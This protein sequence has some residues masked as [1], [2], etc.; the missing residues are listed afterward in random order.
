[1]A[2]FL[3]NFTRKGAARGRTLRDQTADLLEARLWGIG[4]KTANRDALAPEDDILLYVGAP[5]SAFIGHARLAEGTHTW[6]ED[7]SR[8]YPGAWDSGVSFEQASLWDHPIP[9]HSVIAE[10]VLRETNPRA[11]FFGGVVRMTK[12]DYET[13]L[14]AAKVLGSSATAPAEE[15][16]PVEPPGR[17]SEES[18]ADRV[19]EVTESLNS[20][21][22]RHRRSA[23]TTLARF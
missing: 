18:P 13:V 2:Y 22:Q 15:A 8:R 3:F 5:E 9:I 6:T 12:T 19:F 23:S 14:T 20:W 11:Q 16:R 10:L 4:L 1:M 17:Y 21:R 7:E